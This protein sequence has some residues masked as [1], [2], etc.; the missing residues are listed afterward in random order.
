[1]LE[2]TARKPPPLPTVK[3]GAQGPLDDDEEEKLEKLEKRWD[4]YEHREGVIRAQIFSTVPDSILIE[5][6]NHNTAKKMWDALCS[7]F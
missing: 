7:K 1:H 2:G 3:E 4:E 5:I 6:K